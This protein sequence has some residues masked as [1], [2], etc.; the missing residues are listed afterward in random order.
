MQFFHDTHIDFVK[1]R[2]YGYIFSSALIL[3]A[4][5]S[6]IVQKG[7]RYGIDFTGGTSV[8][9]RFQKTTSASELRSSLSDIGFGDAEIKR[10]GPAEENEFIIRVEKMEEG[11]DIAHIIERELSVDLPDNSYDIRTVIDIGPKIGGELRLAAVMAILLSLVGLLIY[12][13]WRFEFKFAIGAIVALFH[14]VLIT[15]GFFSVLKLEISLAVLAAFLTILGYSLNDTIVVFDRI[16]ENLKVLR[17][18]SFSNLINISIN[19]TLSR[20]VI[21]GFTTLISVIILFFI[22]GEVI[23]SFAF[24]LIVGMI[25]GTYSSVFVASPVVYEWQSR[26][27]TQKGRKAL[28]RSSR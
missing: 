14:D 6:L 8:Q 3:I 25:I 10:L 21:T 17:R 13:S 28:L 27:E 26:S 9:L 12:I 2:R 23:H 7:P 5:I 24:A 15:L 16:R 1:L 22:G 4:L 18:E 20:T 19:Q 11:E